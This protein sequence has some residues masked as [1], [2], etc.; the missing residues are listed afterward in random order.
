MN[1]SSF[2][3]IT[4]A[5]NESSK[6]QKVSALYQCILC[7]VKC[8]KSIRGLYQHETLVHYDY[9][10]PPPNISNLPSN[11]I[12]QFRKT[13]IFFI[14][15]R[16]LLNFKKTGRQTIKISCS[17]SQFVSVFGPW[18]QR[19]S[20]CKRKYT[21]L[22]KGQSADTTIAMILQ[23]TEWSERWYEFDQKAYVVLYTSSLSNFQ[24]ELE[25]KIEWYI[26]TII[27][28][29]QNTISTS[30]IAIKFQ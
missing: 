15:K 16:L 22:F 25:I 13:L 7:K 17:E 12:Q 10:T 2:S 3:A 19:Y 28:S 5:N 26:E 11:A 21:C 18:I 1:L 8:F 20:P 9:K 29:H 23:D 30:F 24:K 14:K 27:D 6:N 4:N